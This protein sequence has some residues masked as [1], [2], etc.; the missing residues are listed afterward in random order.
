MGKKRKISSL[1]PDEEVIFKVDPYHVGK[2]EYEFG[3]VLYVNNDTVAVSYLYGYK[4]FT[5]DIPYE[6]MIAVHDEDGVDLNI[7][8]ISG[9]SIKLTYM[10]V[11]LLRNILAAIIVIA[12]AAILIGYRM[13]A[14]GCE[15]P[16]QTGYIYLGDSRFV[17]MNNTIH[18]DEME[19]TFVVA[20][21][22]Q[23]LRWLEDV[24]EDEI[25]DIIE[26]N[27][28]ID[29][30]IIITGLGINDYWN[31]DKYIEY[32]DNIDY[33]Q[34][35]L[36]SVNP[37]EKSKCDIYGYNYTDLSKGAVMFNEKLKETEYPYIDTYTT[38]IDN[39][40]STS[41]GVHYTSTTYQFIYDAIDLYL[42]TYKEVIINGTF[43]KIDNGGI[44]NV[45]LPK[46]S[47]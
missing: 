27:P 33:A 21:V 8:G 44:P 34:L 11:Q 18:M 37:V 2:K 12:I 39:G 47:V 40:F 38:M 25:H 14:Y 45:S 28:E 35:V 17:G 15:A 3:S 32:Y 36:V 43:R 30:W 31:I 4:N 6:D 13:V 23:G 1:Q 16:M 19:N 29:D 5:D 10:K 9:K 46:N 42:N 24:A 20:R 22:G 7:P 26:E 41:D